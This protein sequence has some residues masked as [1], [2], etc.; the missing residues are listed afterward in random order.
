LKVGWR[1]WSA[2]V[3][4]AGVGAGAAVSFGP[5]VRSE[6]AARASRL[7]ARMAVETAYPALD[8]LRLRGVTVELEG[9][10][11]IRVW[12][13]EVRVDWS[14]RRPTAVRGV[15][16]TA[17]GAP[18]EVAQAIEQWR[19]RRGEVGE[20]SIR[21]G[22]ELPT[23]DGV[24][25]DWRRGPSETDDRVHVGDATLSRTVDEAIQLK[26]GSVVA[27]L[28]AVA[29]RVT[30]AKVVVRRGARGWRLVEF[31][32]EGL[33]VS[34]EVAAAPLSPVAGPSSAIPAVNAVPSSA[35]SATGHHRGSAEVSSALG[36][37]PDHEYADSA[38]SPALV[39]RI[40][41][42]R[43]RLQ[44][45]ANVADEVLAP[46]ANVRL[47]GARVRLEIEGQPLDLGP[48]MLSLS[49]VDGALAVELVPTAAN[50][51]PQGAAVD[52]PLRF[53]LTV[54]VPSGPPSTPRPLKA[55]L[56]GGPI[57]LTRLGL[58]EGDLGLSDVSNATLSSDVTIELDAAG[59]VA[60][61]DGSGKIRR[62]SL[63][64]PKL[65]AEPLVG[66][67]LA[68]RAN[69]EARLDGSSADIRAA[70]IDLGDFKLLL[71]GTYRHLGPITEKAP[72]LRH[73]KVD[74][75][76]D[77]PLTN[78]QAIFDSIPKAM[79]PKLVGATF[80][81]SLA[82]RGHVRFDTAALPQSYDVGWEGTQSCRLLEAPEAIRLERFRKPFEKLVY[83]PEGKEQTMSFGPGTPNWIPIAGISK[84]M[85]P[86]VQICEDG[87][88]FRH[89]GFDQEAII[90]SM[91]DNLIAGGFRRGAS[92]ISMQL[93]KNLYLSRDKVLSRKL[94]E[95]ILTLYL[96]QELTKQEILELYFNVIE[97]GPMIYGIGPAARH[98]FGTSPYRLSLGQSLYLASILQN[99]R[100]Q[101]YGAGGAVIPSRMEYLRKLMKLGAKIHLFS[102]AEADEGME[103][104]LVFGRSDTGSGSKED[105]EDDA[106]ADTEPEGDPSPPPSP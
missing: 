98:H 50:E 78:C 84:F 28:G 12:I 68:W 20:G 44:A 26:A 82:A 85:S 41:L 30:A 43:A 32:A 15:K 100:K 72:W 7:G 106:E 40:R 5:A 60:R 74:L 79:V 36:P 59:E 91:R 19:S 17:L 56:S 21:Q 38:D 62:L 96:E 37:A 97:Y 27:R 25:V 54:P 57:A 8:G 101:F 87:H 89:H 75:R 103:E 52:R 92:T 35:V 80:A 13:D 45:I 94:Q 88:F 16:V 42:V 29:A 11:G 1:F 49:R 39:P 24:V 105:A 65:A 61:V 66:I 104:A 83:T 70:E 9:V 64:H 99:P 14:T 90:N 10:Q 33:E 48:G 46:G 6:V 73:A 55:E 4:G 58:K 86:A 23:I 34:R 18:S 22:S 3:V 81:G 71:A 31:D 63:R 53:R 51:P 76:F 47:G 67:E 2:L 102:E 95:A 69:F 77:L 93:A